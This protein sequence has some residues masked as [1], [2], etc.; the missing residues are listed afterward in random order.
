MRALVLLAAVACGPHA[1][2][3]PPSGPYFAGDAQGLREVGPDGKTLRVLTATPVQLWRALPSGDL[4][5]VVRSET[6]DPV[7]LRF[8]ARDG[9]GER[10]LLKVERTVICGAE[11]DYILAVQTDEDLWI[12]PDGG[13]CLKLREDVP[14]AAELE[15]VHRVDPAS[16]RHLSAFLRA[17]PG[18]PAITPRDPCR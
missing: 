10:S 17:P 4:V 9:T 16:G 7:D 8:I 12:T 3:T 13:V 14:R 18:C 15:N 6:L 2:P 11:V 5:F 1:A